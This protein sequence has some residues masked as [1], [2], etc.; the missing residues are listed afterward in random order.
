MTRFMHGLAEDLLNGA[1]VPL[2][3]DVL[4]DFDRARRYSPGRRPS[5]FAGAKK[6]GKE[7][8]SKPIWLLPNLGA[9]PMAA[10]LQL[11]SRLKQFP[12]DARQTFHAGAAHTSPHGSAA[13]MRRR[14]GPS[15]FERSEPAQGEMLEPRGELCPGTVV[16]EVVSVSSLGQ[17]G[18]KVLSF[19]SFSLHQQRKGGRRPGEYRRALSRKASTE[20]ES[21]T[22]QAFEMPKP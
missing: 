13:L 18:F 16:L 15:I 9:L 10:A 17:M 20:R 22:T 14:L 7:S 5:F 11:A 3:R 6:E 4:F 19:A 8:T 2:S 12:L 21:G 1:M